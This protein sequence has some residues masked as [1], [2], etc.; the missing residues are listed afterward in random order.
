MSLRILLVDD[1]ESF[2][3][4]LRIR[5]ES[6]DD[7]LDMT[8]VRSIADG[9]AVLAQSDV[10]LILLDQNLPDGHGI[11]LLE[12]PT[13]TTAAIIAMSSDPAPEIP[14]TVVRAGAT[15]FLTKTQ[16]SAPLFIP[17][18]EGVLARRDI[19]KRLREAELRNERLGSIRMLLATLRH[20]INNPLGAVLGA[21]YL[22]RNAGDLVPN[23]REAL[24]LIES[25]SERI[26]HV[27][28][29]LCHAAEVEELEAVTKAH[30]KVFQVPGDPPWEESN[31]DKK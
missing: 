19:E 13:H 10:D 27:V 26:G 12:P 29:E 7:E 3:S 18:I 6:W 23:Q 31:K 25:S 24:K 17:L 11:E 22:L 4:L 16:V 21:A 20:E 15:Q 1:D 28:R 9:R 8:H 2:A 30:E 5:L 14:G